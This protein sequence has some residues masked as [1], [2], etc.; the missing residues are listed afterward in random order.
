MCVCC[1]L[2]RLERRLKTHVDAEPLNFVDEKKTITC[3][4][5]PRP[6]YQNA[7]TVIPRV[8]HKVA[9]VYKMAFCNHLIAQKF[10]CAEQG[11]REVVSAQGGAPPKKR[12]KYT[13]LREFALGGSF[14]V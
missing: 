13:V 1:S 4:G 7:F 6:R 3:Q 11:R 5:A 10:R 8:I 12:K 2:Y 14:R 9:F